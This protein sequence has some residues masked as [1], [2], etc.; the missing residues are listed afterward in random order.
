MSLAIPKRFVEAEGVLHDMAMAEVGFSDFGPD[1]YLAGLRALLSAI[2][3]DLDPIGPVRERVFGMILAALI[4]R[5]FSQKG[6]HEDPG[7]L[8][9]EIRRPLIVT[10][11]IR[12]GTT[13]LQKVLA[14]DPQFQGLEY[15]LAD[16]PMVRPQRRRWRTHPLYQIAETNLNAM[17]QANPMIGAIHQMAADEADECLNI[18]RQS[19]ISNMFASQLHIPSYDR[20]WM[21]QESPPHIIAIATTCA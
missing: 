6:W 5:L 10:G 3:T 8:R 18:M 12:S 1:D 20:W 2:D 4:S 17:L 9:A 14:L 11:I 15:W 13:P 16:T 21:A 19:F 7:C